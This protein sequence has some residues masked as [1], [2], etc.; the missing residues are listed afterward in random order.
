MAELTRTDDIADNDLIVVFKEIDQ[1]Y[2]GLQ[3]VDLVGY[4][5]EEVRGDPGPTGPGVPVGGTAGQVLSK[6]GPDDFDT[7]WV[8]PPNDSW[9]G[10]AGTLSDQT[11]LQNALNAKVATTRNVNTTS[12]LTGGGALSADLTIGLNQSLITI[13]ESQV[14]NLTSDLAGKQATLVSGTNIKTINSQTLLGSGDITIAGTAG[15][16]TVY[17][18][19]ESNIAITTGEKA[20][21]IVCPVA[22]NI[23]GWRMTSY[24]ATTAAVS[25]WKTNNARPT[26]ANVIT[27]SAP[28]TLTASAISSGTTLTGWATSVAAGDAFVMNVDSNSA[29][30]TIYVALE[31]Q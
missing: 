21:L 2:R 29:A 9:G 11:D 1:K 24:P 8:D 16:T 26:V 7:E 18:S 19:G 17:F 23:V 28:P 10:I 27:A 13:A 25:I 30:T 14:T 20:P 31:I 12:P 6:V 5:D 3:A 22:G 15:T 4:L